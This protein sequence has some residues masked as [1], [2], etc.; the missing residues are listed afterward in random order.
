MAM[1]VRPVPTLDAEVNDTR[2][3]TAE[4]VNQDILPAEDS[5]GAGWR[6][7]QSAQGGG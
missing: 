6:R 3:A 1:N 4:I 7:A 5:Y 2:Q